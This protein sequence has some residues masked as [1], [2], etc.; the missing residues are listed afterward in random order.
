MRNSERQRQNPWL[1]VVLKFLPPA[2]SAFLKVEITSTIPPFLL[3][4][5]YSVLIPEKP[6]S[7]CMFDTTTLVGVVIRGV[8]EK[9]TGKKGGNCLLGDGR[10]GQR[11]R[12]EYIFSWSF[13]CYDCSYSQLA[14]LQNNDGL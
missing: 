6:N 12:R 11:R 14:G 3:L 1:K 13:D 10:I 2:Q 7:W 9:K 8:G 4:L 5:I